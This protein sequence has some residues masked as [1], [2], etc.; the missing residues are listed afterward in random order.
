MEE[1]GFRIDNPEKA[2]WALRKYAALVK[3]REQNDSL[4]DKEIERVRLWRDNANAAIEGNIEFF[5]AHLEAF[6]MQQRIA[7][8]KTFDSPSGK[9][10]SRQ[11]TPSFE[12]DK[13]TFV[14]WAQSNNRDDLLRFTVAP[15]LPAIKKA[16]VPHGEQVF[17]PFTGESVPGVTPVP[18]KI[19]FTIEPD[20]DMA[21]LGDEEDAE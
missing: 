15:D 14:D 8:V 13:T 21:D 9:I 17:D 11:T 1:E 3:K 18:E 2:A 5:A 19:T 10:K 4:A 12:V 7:G 16:L 20:M 6:A